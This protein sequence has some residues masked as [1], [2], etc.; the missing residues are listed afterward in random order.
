LR[1]GAVLPAYFEDALSFMGGGD[2]YA[3]NLARAL[4]GSC[5]VTLISFGPRRRELDSDGLRH[6]VL[7]ASGKDPDNPRPQLGPLLRERFDVIHVFQLR[8][9]VSS[10]LAAVCRIR[11]I[12]LVVTDAG[13]GGR[14]MMYRLRLYSLVPSFVLISDFSRTLLPKSVWSRSLVVKGGIDLARFRFSE[15][16]RQRQVLQVGRIMPHKG[17]NYLLEAAAMDIPVVVAGKVIDPNYYQY[18]RQQSEGRPV[19]F[20]V[21]APDRVVADLYA[22]SAVTVAASVY[23]DVFGRDWPNSELLGLTLLE[24]MAVGTPVVCTNVG[25]MPEYVADGETGYVVPPNDPAAI[26]ARLDLLLSDPKLAAQLGRAGHAHVQQFSW[27]RVADKVAAEY[28][29]LA[30]G[31]RK[32]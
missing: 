2:R 18:L 31:K 22:Q 9:L 12:P 4:R 1:V 13:G 14:S 20:L 19:T 16:P 17:I 11:G 3:Y 8:S 25:G 30:S 21:D 27:Q 6:L 15:A 24:S 32:S 5:E 23:R 28:S 10:M 7:P 29:R 26:R